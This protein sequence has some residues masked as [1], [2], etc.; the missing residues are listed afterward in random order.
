M[1]LF[2]KKLDPLTDRSKE[3]AREIAS[4]EAE[5]QKLSSRPA[6]RPTPAPAN[7]PT[8]PTLR[9]SVRAN[10]PV[11]EEVKV[12]QLASHPDGESTSGHYNDLG[13]R[14]YDLPALWRRIRNHFYGPPPTNPKL[15]NYLAA[16]SIHGVRPLRYES[17][18]ARNRFIA[19]TIV[20]ALLIWGF[21]AMFLKYR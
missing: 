19:A 3:L 17:R 16:G 8:G 6:P 7:T 4:L 21:L 1:P 18:I 14:K 10:D 5:I 13:V 9:A 15:I 11:F 20:L 12:K 2:K